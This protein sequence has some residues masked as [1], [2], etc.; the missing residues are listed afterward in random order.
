MRDV[1]LFQ[2]A[3]GL[4]SPWYVKRTEFDADARRLDLYLDF[5]EGGR[6]T[7]PECGAGRLPGREAE[8][9]GAFR[10]DLEA[11][12]G[13]PARIWELCMDM[14]PA[15][16]KGAREHLTQA[17][18]TFDCFHVHW[19]HTRISNGLLEGLSS[20]VQATKAR[21]RGYRSTTKLT[22][23]IYLMHGKLPLHQPIGDSEEPKFGLLCGEPKS[24]LFQ[25]ST[26]LARG[27]LPPPSRRWLGWA[28]RGP[29]TAH[30]LVDAASSSGYSLRSKV[31]R[32]GP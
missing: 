28:P 23:M 19:F 32:P 27:L 5:R 31:W 16:Q 8:T 9:I 18:T 30:W 4:E 7:C 3:L 13:E 1:E 12:G 14:S 29:A 2:M 10:K 17:R 26:S 24:G 15:Y 20:L 22:A 6:F 21:A 25:Q 11:H